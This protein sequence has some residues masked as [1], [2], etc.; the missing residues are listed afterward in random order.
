MTDQAKRSSSVNTTDHYASPNNRTKKMSC[1]ASNDPNPDLNTNET[2]NTKLVGPPTVKTLLMS[3]ETAHNWCVLKNDDDEP[4][5]VVD[6]PMLIPTPLGLRYKEPRWTVIQN[7]K[8]TH[9]FLPEE[10]QPEHPS[11]KTIQTDIK[12]VLKRLEL[13]D[14]NF[15]PI[16][17]TYLLANLASFHYKKHLPTFRL[18]N[19]FTRTPPESIPDFSELEGCLFFLPNLFSEFWLA[20]VTVFGLVYRPFACGVK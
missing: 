5:F 2:N 17:S 19:C 4:M 8:K 6:N 10:F 16:V 18:A 9:R 11:F 13:P 1:R 7:I 20:S 14:K 12:T 15:Y 3:F